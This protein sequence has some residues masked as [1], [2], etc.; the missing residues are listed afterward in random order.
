MNK[1]IEEI[2]FTEKYRPQTLDD[3]IMP[4]RYKKRFS[5]GLTSNVL[6]YGPP[7]CGKSTVA[8]AIVK[9]FGHPYLYI[10]CSKD[11]GVD[12]IREEITDFCINQSLQTS[13]KSNNTKVVILDELD[14]ASLQ[15]FKALRAS[16]EEFKHVRFIA[17]CNYINKIPEPLQDRRFEV[18]NFEFTEDDIKELK[19]GYANRL[20]IICKQEEIKLVVDKDETGKSMSPLKYL[21]D[22]YY[23]DMAA[24]LNILQ[25]FKNEGKNELTC[26]DVQK[27]YS[28]YQKV[29]D[30]VCNLEP[31]DV[32]YKT[33]VEQYS[34]KIDSV[35][36]SFFSDFGKFIESN[37]PEL[38][39]LFP[40]F[41]IKIAEYQSKRSSVIDQLLIPL[42]LIY[43][44]QEIIKNNKT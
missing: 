23:P 44:L 20:M 35:L 19:Q 2:L 40:L 5:N 14:G 43:E 32:V 30:L 39:K 31:S 1:H 28:I 17:T 9:Q 4:E 7:G 38:L 36:S 8:K 33:I 26:S 41:I 27:S 22:K 13:K 10:N 25:G 18:I 16:M 11:T 15:F 42:A 12:I 34:S 29:F 3:I 37:R 21:F 24:M 6:L